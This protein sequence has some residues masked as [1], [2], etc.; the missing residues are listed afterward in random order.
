V[1]LLLLFAAQ[2]LHS[3][4]LTGLVPPLR[5]V[6]AGLLYHTML[7]D[8]LSACSQVQ[9]LQVCICFEKGLLP[10]SFAG[11]LWWEIQSGRSRQERLG[12]AVESAFRK[13]AT[14]VL[15]TGL[16]PVL[17]D[18]ATLEGA[19]LALDSHSVVIGKGL[20]G[21]KR[22]LPVLLQAEPTLLWNQAQALGLDAFALPGGL[23]FEDMAELG[24]ELG[25]H[26]TLAPLCASVVASLA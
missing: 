14:K 2:P 18:K 21:L 1:N 17:Q 12:R 13:G 22:N 23:G 24:R 10:G 8:Q 19:L 5:P 20:L 7:R 11:D 3:R 6:Q 26:P 16:D 4:V 9:G 15:A 25:R